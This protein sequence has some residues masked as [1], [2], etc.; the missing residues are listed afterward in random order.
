MSFVNFSG[1]TYTYSNTLFYITR[2]IVYKLL[3][4]QKLKKMYK[5]ITKEFA[6]QTRKELKLIEGQ[7]STIT[8]I[9]MSYLIGV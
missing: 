8:I 4:T 2:L 3:N 6:T 7:S 1:T 5:T 9:P